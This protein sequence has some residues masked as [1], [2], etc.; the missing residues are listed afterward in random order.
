[1][2][3]EF[4][5]RLEYKSERVGREF[6]VIDRWYPS[7]KTCSKRETSPVRVGSPRHQARAEVNSMRFVGGGG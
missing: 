2:G 6:V 7:S 5:R 1:V 3:G 4:R